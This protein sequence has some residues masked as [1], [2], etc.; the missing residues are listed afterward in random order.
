MMNDYLDTAEDFIVDSQAEEIEDAMED[1]EE[2]DYSDI[3]NIA[4]I[5][6]DSDVSDYEDTDEY[7]DEDYD[8]DDDYVDYH[9]P[10]NY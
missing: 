8:D 2:D 6:D 9:V 10:D 5:D 3:D 1:L 4:G 7:D